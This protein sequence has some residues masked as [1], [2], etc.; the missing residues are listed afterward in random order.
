LLLPSADLG[1]STQGGASGAG[2]VGGTGVGGAGSPVGV[3]TR[4]PTFE[5]E[6]AGRLVSN[7]LAYRPPPFASNIFH[8]PRAA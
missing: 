7:Y 2:A 5:L 3:F 4:P 6:M 1:L 8:P